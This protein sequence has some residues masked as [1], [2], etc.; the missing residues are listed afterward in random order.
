VLTARAEAH[1]FWFRGFRRFVAPVLREAARGRRDLRLVDCGCG[2]G[3]NLALLRPYGRVVGFDRA[4]VPPH[5]APGERLRADVTRIPF[6]TGTFDLATS[7]DVFQCLP[8]DGPAVAEM[9]RI[10]KPGG[11]LVLTM[12]AL[13]VLRGDHSESW[14]EYRRYTPRTASQLVQ[15]S[16]LRVERTS[17]LF[18]SV[19]PL[20]LVR[21]AAQRL[22]RLWRGPRP[23]AD[24]A[25]PPRPVNAVLAG[26]V[27]AEAAL[28]GRV[29]IPVG[30]SLLI[31]ARKP[32]KEDD[33]MTIE[34]GTLRTNH[35][36]G[37]SGWALLAAGAV[38]FGV[39]GAI[40]GCAR[41]CR[42]GED[43]W[44]AHPRAEA[45]TVHVTPPHGDV[46]HVH[47]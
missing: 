18:G 31:V 39:V 38:A 26:L 33:T 43:R 46:L 47:E 17:F 6:A 37:P 29:R 30:S 9:A 27:T 36:A 21:R 32:R 8:D 23:A 7:F 34:T 35:D 19:F 25:V 45:D 16:G 14:R 41:S 44:M 10:V 24:I 13:E 42:A 15:E 20:L 28:A 12:A 2:T 11:V 3:S 5:A 4:M 22:A 1:H 40:I